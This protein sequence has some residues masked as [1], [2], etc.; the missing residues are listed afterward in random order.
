MLECLK[1]YHMSHKKLVFVFQKKLKSTKQIGIIVKDNKGE[2][3]LKKIE[4]KQ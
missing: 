3:A 2:Q 1:H 4:M